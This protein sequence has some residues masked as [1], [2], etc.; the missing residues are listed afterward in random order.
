MNAAMGKL[1]DGQRRLLVFTGNGGVGKTTLAAATALAAARAGKR[2]AILTIDP[3]PRLGDALGVGE[4]GGE[5]R[6][7][8]LGDA[9][10]GRLVAMRLDTQGTFDRLVGNLAPS[11][12]A[13]RRLLANPVYRTISGALG[14]SDSYMALQRLYELSGDPSHELLVLDTPPAVHAADLLSAPLRLSAVVETGA[15][16]MLANPAIALARAGSVVARMPATVLLAVLERLAGLPLRRQVAEFI[17]GFE[18]VLAGLSSRANKVEEMLRADTTSFCLVVRPASDS[19]DRGLAL[20]DELG[21]AGV[22]VRVIV[23]N[24]MTAA[25]GAERRIARGR[26]LAGAPDGTDEAVAAMERELDLLRSTETE[27]LE[28]LRRLGCRASARAASRPRAPLL[29]E[30][31]ALESELGSL[32]D[33]DRLAGSIVEA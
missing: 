3:A 11:P 30:V 24:R 1:A 20:L 18:S 5:P 13:A 21:E 6:E 27:A 22:P 8:D 29:L 7:I 12:E 10:G 19:V 15:A 25:R 26:R 4:L 33:L 31:P 28:R 16:R 14:G 9:Q 17:E 32:A 2:V 23:A